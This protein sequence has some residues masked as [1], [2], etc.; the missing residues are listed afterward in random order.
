MGAS[1][2]PTELAD[3]L[4]RSAVPATLGRVWPLLIAAVVARLVI[5][6][7]TE[8]V[9]GRGDDVT[10]HVLDLA[11]AGGGLALL[12]RGRRLGLLLVGALPLLHAALGFTLVLDEAF[13]G[14]C[15][16]TGQGQIYTCSPGAGI[17]ALYDPWTV[18]VLLDLSV[19]VAVVVAYKRLVGRTVRGAAG[20]GRDRASGA[21]TM[22]WSLVMA[23]VVVAQ[24]SFVLYAFPMGLGLHPLLWALTMVFTVGALM[25]AV[26]WMHQKRRVVLVLPPAT[27]VVLVL[28][29]TL[30]AW[31]Y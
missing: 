24:A 22:G 7:T 27:L 29:H 6:P 31:M 25:L 9:L 13:G 16:P 4:E 2:P 15:V 21:S 20:P 30:A 14:E 5:V 17:G 28:M 3:D 26:A 10:I 8:L 23:A 1:Q 18:M 12:W 11:L 19:V